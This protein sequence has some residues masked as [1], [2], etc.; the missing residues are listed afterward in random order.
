MK[1][2]ESFGG[3]LIGRCQQR[4]METTDQKWGVFMKLVWEAN[5]D[6]L[7]SPELEVGAK[8]RKADPY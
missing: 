3:N 4:G 8:I 2:S 1:K 5:L 6:F 7:A